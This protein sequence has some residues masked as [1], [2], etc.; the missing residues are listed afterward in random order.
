M[1]CHIAVSAHCFFAFSLTLEIYGSI[2]CTHVLLNGAFEFTTCKKDYV[3]PH[4]MNKTK[5][6]VSTAVLNAKV[7]ILIL[8]EGV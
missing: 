8:P 7:Y 3:L 2:E 5:Q 1:S 4:P 6:R